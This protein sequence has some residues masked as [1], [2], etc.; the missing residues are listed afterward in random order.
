MFNDFFIEGKQNPSKI[1]FYLNIENMGSTVLPL[2]CKSISDKGLA[3]F[4]FAA[5]KTYR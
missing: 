1:R 2:D 5:L 4:S 3:R